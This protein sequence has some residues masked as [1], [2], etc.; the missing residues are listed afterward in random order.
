MASTYFFAKFFLAP[1]KPCGTIAGERKKEGTD[2]LLLGERASAPSE[3]KQPL[4]METPTPEVNRIQA[5]TP[6]ATTPTTGPV[7]ISKSLSAFG[8]PTQGDTEELIKDRYLCRGGGLMLFGGTGLGKSSLAIQLPAQ[9]ALGQGDFGI[10][11]A[12]P[13]RSLIIQSENDDG[14]IAEFRDGTFAG[15]GYSGSDINKI[16]ENVFV[17]TEVNKRGRPFLREVVD[18]LVEHHKPDLVWI[19]HALAY[20]NKNPNSPQDVGEFLRE[21]LSQAKNG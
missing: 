6:S 3:R 18:P 5:Q 19:D 15:Y 11:P 17:Y 13:L 21:W 2:T 1:L 4:P 20:F 12:R 14:D 10:E 9:F 7:L 8:R 16:Q